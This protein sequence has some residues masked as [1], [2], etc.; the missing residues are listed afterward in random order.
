MAPRQAASRSAS[1]AV[2]GHLLDLLASGL[3]GSHDQ[4]VPHHVRPTRSRRLAGLALL[5]PLAGCTAPQ[6]IPSLEPPPDQVDLV[7]RWQDQD[8]ADVPDGRHDVLTLA[9]GVGSTS[10]SDR[11][12]TVFL[13]LAW[14]AGRRLDR[15][16]ATTSGD[17]QTYVRD[18]H[19]SYWTQEQ[20]DLDTRLPAAARA[21][22]LHRAGNELYTVPSDPSRIWISRPDGRIERWPR[23]R[24]GTGCG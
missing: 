1:H 9:A 21:T 12:V 5:V 22:G 10:C 3:D 13:E 4:E 7:G 11:D 2:P 17:H 24:P 6:T 20:P 15:N 16:Q 8:G 18:P 19:G 14:P 23:Q